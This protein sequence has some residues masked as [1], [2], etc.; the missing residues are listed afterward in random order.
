[1]A[2][3]DKSVLLGI[4]VI[5]AIERQEA[6]K[7]VMKCRFCE[8]S[9]LYR[10]R[11]VSPKFRCYGCKKAFDEPVTV[12]Q[13]VLQYRARYDAE[14]IDLT[15]TLLAPEIRPLCVSPRSQLS[16][17]PIVWSS[18]MAA[19]R[20]RVTDRVH[21]QIPLDNSSVAREGHRE[22]RT[23]ARIGQSDFR[24][25]LLE[26]FGENCALT[27]PTPPAALEAAHL[28]SYASVGKHHLHGGL[29]LRRDVHRLFD[30]GDLAI[31]PD[32]LSIDADP[33]LR[34]YK[35]Y[36]P[37]HGRKLHVE[38]EP[39]HRAWIERHWIRH[40]VG[41]SRTLLGGTRSRG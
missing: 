8:K 15:S 28:Y 1:M 3:W 36:S 32:R 10:R 40:R 27:G 13:P 26:R 39:Q 35:N 20:H 25:K 2:I 23:R 7:T 18:L 34:T 21:R 19:L 11:N 38:V 33:S 30:R 6:T 12:V 16:L 29:L 24:E 41:A 4:S 9:T 22:I 14:W 17:R 37:L 5:D 31:H